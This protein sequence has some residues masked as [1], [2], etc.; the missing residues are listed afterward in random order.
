MTPP[1]L[2]KG[3]GQNIFTAHSPFH[4]G[5]VNLSY[6]GLRGI[7]VSRGLKSILAISKLSL[8]SRAPLFS[9]GPCLPCISTRPRTGGNFTRRFQRFRV[10]MMFPRRLRTR[11][12]RRLQKPLLRILTRSPETTCGGGPSCVCKVT[13]TSCSVQ[14]AITRKVLAMGRIAEHARR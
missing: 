3:R 9:V 14:F 6:I 8:L 5:S 11:L 7:H 12:P 10:P 4:P 2:K 13:F 1:H